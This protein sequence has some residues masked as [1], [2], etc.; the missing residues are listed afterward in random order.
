M[1]D[2]CAGCGDGNLLPGVLV[3]SHMTTSPPAAA[4]CSTDVVSSS[5]DVVSSIVIEFPESTDGIITLAEV[6]KVALKQ[7]A[8]RKGSG[9]KIGMRHRN[10]QEAGWTRTLIAAK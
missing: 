3:P 7:S 9:R 5:T 8:D 10:D 6:R 1:E 2:H 4:G